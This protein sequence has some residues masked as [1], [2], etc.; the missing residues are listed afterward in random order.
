M[1]NDAHTYHVITGRTEFR[2]AIRRAFAKAA[3]VGCREMWICDPDFADWPLGEVEV[4]D[5]LTRWASPHRKLTMLALTYDE[6]LRRHPRFVDWRRRW[7][8]V[9]DCRAEK[10]VDA[11]DIPS[12]LLAPGVIAL[13]LL[14]RVRFRASESF[15]NSDFVH[16]HEMVDAISQRSNEAFPATLLGL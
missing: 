15:E 9:I 12:L 2:E 6:V 10:D 5:S 7:A 1:D 4:V 14:D 16:C 13:R 11:G 3:D 8:H